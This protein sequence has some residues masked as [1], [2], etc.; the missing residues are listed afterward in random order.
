MGQLVR[1]LRIL[2]G[3]L[4]ALILLPA[5]S[6]SNADAVGRTPPAPPPPV[7]LP[8]PRTP[9]PV[10]GGDQAS[11]ADYPWVVYLTDS[12]DMQFCGGAIIA[13]NK[14][15]TAAHCVHDEQPDSLKVVAGRE[16]KDTKA[17]TVAKVTGIWSDPEYRSP[18]GGSDAAVVTL[19]RDLTQPPVQLASPTDSPLYKAGTPATVLGWGATREGGATSNT[20]RKADLPVAA[21]KD[22]SAAYGGR[23]RADAMVCAGV[24][25][26][27]VD[28][29]QGDSGGPLVADGKLI[30][31]VS[32]GDGCARP[33]RYGVYSRVAS[34]YDQLEQQIGS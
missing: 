24:P 34:Y 9:A 16:N 2:T 18:Y 3:M 20:L 27:G 30:G 13:P 22:C 14:V 31:L 5:L 29:C 7:P 15:V 11:L 28:S 21:D 12:H 26:G 23:F 8:H 19:D 4:V 1:R 10:V 6:T 32:W 33:H 25:Q 17:G